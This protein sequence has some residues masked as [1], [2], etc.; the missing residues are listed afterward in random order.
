MMTKHLALLSNNQLSTGGYTHD[1]VNGGVAEFVA[2]EN[3]IPGKYFQMVHT[4]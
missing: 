2:N 3:V 4:L 1:G